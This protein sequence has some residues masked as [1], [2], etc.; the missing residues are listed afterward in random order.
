MAQ[1]SISVSD[2]VAGRC[3]FISFPEIRLVQ[4]LRAYLPGW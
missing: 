1:W 3:A 2:G 4:Y